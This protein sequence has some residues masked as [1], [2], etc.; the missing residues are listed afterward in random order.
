M[1]AT[2]SVAMLG[3][4]TTAELGDHAELNTSLGNA[5]QE[6]R[7]GA[8]HHDSITSGTGGGAIGGDAG[9]GGAVDTAVESH[10]TTARV[11]NASAQ[12]QQAVAVQARASTEITQAAIAVGGGA[13]AGLAGTGALILLDGTTQA[14]VHNADLASQGKLSVQARSDTGIDLI[15]GA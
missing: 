11:Q 4:S 13:Y 14:L 5:A 12:A 1:A 9:L 3:G 2:V 8:F 15:A 6:A 10:T 7:V